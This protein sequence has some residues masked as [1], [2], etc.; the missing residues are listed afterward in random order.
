M[1][2]ELKITG[3]IKVVMPIEKGVSKADKEWQKLDFVIETTDGAFT[4]DIAFTLFGDKV[5]LIDGIGQG[6]TVTVSFNL[7]SREYNGKWYSNINAWKVTPES[8]AAGYVPPTPQTEQAVNDTP[9]AD[10]PF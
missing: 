7:N 5:S 2:N 10:L 8:V 1:S 9:A 3:V 6:Q 4:N